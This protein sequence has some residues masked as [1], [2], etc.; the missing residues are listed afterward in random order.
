MAEP[1][2]EPAE[3]AS[4]EVEASVEVS[5]VDTEFSIELLG[6][7]P[8]S[9]PMLT[10]AKEDQDKDLA[11]QPPVVDCVPL[12]LTSDGCDGSGRSTAE[13]ST[14]G[15]SSP[16]PSTPGSASES[17]QALLGQLAK[18]PETYRPDPDPEV[19]KNM[20]A[21]LLAENTMKP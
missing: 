1:P 10:A 12:Q 18:I 16:V 17:L 3:E 21:T 15:S 6:D 2:A 8:A 14:P 11:D 9:S 7:W 20:R 13:T 4:S 5:S 19:R